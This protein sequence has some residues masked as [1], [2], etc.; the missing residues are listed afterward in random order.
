MKKLVYT[1]LVFCLA[2]CAVPGPSFLQTASTLPRGGIQV[3]AGV[4]TGLHFEETAYRKLNPTQI[5]AGGEPNQDRAYKRDFMIWPGIFNLMYLSNAA[6]HAA[7]GFRDGLEVNGSVFLG[8]YSAGGR[9]ACKARLYQDATYA[10]SI[11]PGMLAAFSKG[12]KSP[13]DQD[14]TGQDT[15]L[16]YILND[17]RVLGMEL[18]LLAS[19]TS[20]DWIYTAIPSLAYY[21]INISKGFGS[22]VK[23]A[24]GVWGAGLGFSSQL[25]IWKIRFGP[26][27]SLSALDLTRKPIVN[28]NY[29]FGGGIEL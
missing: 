26:E 17:K 28:A 20:G 13:G 23:G 4:G 5:Q 3:L 12:G 16:Q 18:P 24:I 21:D 14:N 9:L 10:L 25:R 19:V 11:N 22:S 8:G 2:G 27:I 1:V 7:Y 15:Y 29:G 6:V